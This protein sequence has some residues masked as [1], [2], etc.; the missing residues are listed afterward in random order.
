MLKRNL[1]DAQGLVDRLLE[2]KT[3]ATVRNPT[4]KSLVSE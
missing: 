4:V 3:F 1:S 2:A